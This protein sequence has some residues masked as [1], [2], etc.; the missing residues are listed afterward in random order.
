MSQ[1]QNQMAVD[2]RTGETFPVLDDI[3]SQSGGEALLSAAA[4]SVFTVPSGKALILTSYGVY[5]RGDGGGVA[6]RMYIFASTTGAAAQ[7]TVVINELGTSAYLGET[8]IQGIVIIASISSFCYIR[9]NPGAGTGFFRIGG[10]IRDRVN[11]D[12]T[13]P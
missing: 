5:N 12:V 1:M 9:G 10:L 8:G 7:R 2:G 13:S 6:D 11:G 3:R 4:G